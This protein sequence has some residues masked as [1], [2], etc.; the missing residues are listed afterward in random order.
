MAPRPRLVPPAPPGVAY[1]S[2]PYHSRNARS[3]SRTARSY[4]WQQPPPVLRPGSGDAAGYPGRIFWSPATGPS[5]R[6]APSHAGCRPAAGTRR[7]GRR[8]WNPRPT[9]C[10]RPAARRNWRTRS[11]W[12]SRRPARESRRVRCAFAARPPGR[13]SRRWDGTDWAP[14]ITASRTS[15]GYRRSWQ[16]IAVAGRRPSKQRQAVAGREPPAIRFGQLALGISMDQPAAAVEDGQ[17]VVQPPSG[18]DGRADQQVDFSPAAIRPRVAGLPHFGGLQPAEIAG[19][20]CGRALGEQHHVGRRTGRLDRRTVDLVQIAGNRIGELHL[21]GRHAEPA[22]G[23]VG[24][25]LHSLL[26]NDK[27]RVAERGRPRRAALAGSISRPLSRRQ[28]KR[29]TER[30]HGDLGAAAN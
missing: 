4:L 30:A 26:L 7:R 12:R 22:G 13:P 2:R 6:R 20:A 9:T 24:F 21:D 15:S 27:V 19:V 23:D 5:R 10:R 17:A 3:V 16:M 29:R 8:S 28:G 11:R 14:A 1:R 25:G 18:E